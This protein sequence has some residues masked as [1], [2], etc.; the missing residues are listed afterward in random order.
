MH[1]ENRLSPAK[2]EGQTR[3]GCACKL[4]QKQLNT[5]EGEMGGEKKENAQEFPPFCCCWTWE[6]LEWKKTEREG[7]MFQLITPHSKSRDQYP[8]SACTHRI[9]ASSTLD[10]MSKPM[11]DGKGVFPVF[12]PTEITCPIQNLS[13]QSFVFMLGRRIVSNVL[14]AQ[15]AVVNII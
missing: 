10:P 3:L 4:G 15:S 7:Q 8:P 14:S 11:I 5:Q 13:T 9:I 6:G 12:Y 1:H 2:V